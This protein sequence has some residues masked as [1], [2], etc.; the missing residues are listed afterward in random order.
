VNLIYGSLYETNNRFFSHFLAA[1]ADFR[2]NDMSEN[3]FLERCYKV[4][5]LLDMPYFGHRIRPREQ[6]NYR[7]GAMIGISG[8]L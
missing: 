4:I 1:S 6:Q 7:P 8:V 3:V 5:V 2:K